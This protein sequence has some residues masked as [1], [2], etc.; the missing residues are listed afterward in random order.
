V[1]SAPPPQQFLGP[2]QGLSASVIARLTEQ[3]RSDA[4]AFGERFLADP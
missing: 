1:I 2:E 4:R 3:W